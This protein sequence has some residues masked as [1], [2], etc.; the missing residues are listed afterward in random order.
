MKFERI[1]KNITGISTPIFGIQWNP[2]VVEINIA[3]D[4]IL[5]LED[6]RILFNPIDM[7]DENQV[8]Y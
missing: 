7:E 2:P 8:Y 6:K 4:I 3:K 1:L 5:F